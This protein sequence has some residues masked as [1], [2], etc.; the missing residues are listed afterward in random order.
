MR[1]ILASASPRRAELLASAGFT[2]E[3]LPADVDETPRHGEAA[4]VY[5]ERVARDKARRAAQ[6]S[7]TAEAMVLGADTEVVIDGRILGK[8]AHADAAAG[9]LRLL[10]GGTHEVLTAVVLR[11]AGRERS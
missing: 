1:L 4:G 10:S 7:S 11:A 8:P 9:M 3:V 2:F 5:T 6:L